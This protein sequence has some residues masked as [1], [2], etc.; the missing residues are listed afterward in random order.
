M[1][2]VRVR[3]FGVEEELLLIHADTLQPAAVAEQVVERARPRAS[4][5]HQ[6]TRE[7]KQEQ[8]EVVSP[9]Q[10]TLAGQLAAIRTG[11]S[12]AGE[13]AAEVGT[14]VVALPTAPGALIPTWS[15][16]HV[17]GR[18]GTVSGSLRLSSSPAVSTFMWRSAPATKGWLSSTGSAVGCP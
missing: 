11:R 10:T 14:R 18:S 15:P 6:I 5:A 8:V 1:H 17:S 4:G 7:L 16:R 9:P 2:P 3:Q 12:L 13:A